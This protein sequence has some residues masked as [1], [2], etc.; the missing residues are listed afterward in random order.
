MEFRNL[1]LFKLLDYPRGDIER[2]RELSLKLKASGVS[3]LSFVSKGYRGVVFKAYYEGKPVAVK[4]KRADSQKPVVE[5]EFTFLTHLYS[6]YGKETPAPI[7]YLKG[8]DFIVMEWVEGTDFFTAF[9]ERPKE[10]CLFAL[11][12]C[13]KL[14]RA[15]VEHSEIKGEKHLVVRK[16]DLKVIDFESAKFK[17]F[18]RNLLQFVGYYLVGRELY[19]ELGIPKRELLKALEVYKKEPEKGYGLLTTKLLCL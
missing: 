1:R 15:K 7:P 13:Y 4:V 8:E 10:V 5:K 6:L 19:K 17:E 2:G 16:E 18:P 12:S 11:S 3:K 14:D 9:K